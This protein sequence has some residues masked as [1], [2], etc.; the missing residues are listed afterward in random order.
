MRQLADEIGDPPPEVEL[1][2]LAFTARCGSTL[3]CQMFANLPGTLVMTEPRAMFYAHKQYN[4]GL[5]LEKDYVGILRDIM[6]VQFKMPRVRTFVLL[7]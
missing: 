5:I 6:R 4:Q 7:A 2:S 1:V 3:L